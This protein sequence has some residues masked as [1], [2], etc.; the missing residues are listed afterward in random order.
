MPCKIVI[1]SYNRADRVITKDICRDVI[2]C[3]P[4]S[5]EKDYKYYNPDTEIV[6]HPDSVKGF[7]PK[8]NWMANHFKELFMIDDDIAYVQKMYIEKGE[9][10][11]IRD[12]DYVYDIIQKLYEMAKLLGVSV[13]GF[14]NR[15]TPFQYD[16]FEPFSLT[17]RVTGCSYGVIKNEN[18]VWNEDIVLKEDF[19]ISSYVLYKER[20]ILVDNRYHFAQKDTFVNPGGLSEFRSNQSE[21]KSILAIRKHF[22]ESIVIKT[23]VNHVNKSVKYNIT[24]KY[25]I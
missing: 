10:S 13:F 21:M 8:R 6:T 18:V 22:G 9:Q 15:A 3:V 25:R 16:E 19:W 14:G 24:S 2:I 5:Q 7:P 17:K 12:K 23:A 11:A 20:R 4:E 1:P